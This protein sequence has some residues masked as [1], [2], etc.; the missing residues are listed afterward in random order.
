MKNDR[1]NGSRYWKRY[2]FLRRHVKNFHPPSHRFPRMRPRQIP[3]NCTIISRNFREITSYLTPL[4]P[5]KFRIYKLFK[6]SLLRDIIEA[7]SPPLLFHYSQFAD[8]K[9]EL[10]GIEGNFAPNF[11][12]PLLLFQP[13]LNLEEC[14]I[15]ACGREGGKLV[16]AWNNTTVQGAQNLS[17][18][19]SS[20]V[21]ILRLYRTSRNWWQLIKCVIWT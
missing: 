13:P 7:S 6:L 1:R 2:V 4:V 11:H 16:V 5:R 19:V 17:K 20:S 21:S 10:E 12:P 14:N 9:L 3:P 8:N 18:L 15:F